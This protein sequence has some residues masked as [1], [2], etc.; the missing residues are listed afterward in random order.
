METGQIDDGNLQDALMLVANHIRNVK[1]YSELHFQSVT[2]IAT[3]PDNIWEVVFVRSPKTSMI[4]TRYEFFVN[5]RT[6]EIKS[7]EIT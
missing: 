1:K 5:L 7:N 6:G 4:F 2:R 3:Q